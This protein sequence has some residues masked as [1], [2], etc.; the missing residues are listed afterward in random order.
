MAEVYEYGS[1][2]WNIFEV[3]DMSDRGV[4]AFTAGGKGDLKLEKSSLSL[5]VKV[6]L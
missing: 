1:G 4:W 5:V 3:V 6:D 2:G